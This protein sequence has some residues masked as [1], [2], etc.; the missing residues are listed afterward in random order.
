MGSWHLPLVGGM[1]NQ[2][3]FSFGEHNCAFTV[4]QAKNLVLHYSNGCFWV[5]HFQ[6]TCSMNKKSVQSEENMEKNGKENYYYNGSE[7]WAHSLWKFIWS[8][9]RF[10]SPWFEPQ[11]SCQQCLLAVKLSL[12]PLFKAL[13]WLFIWNVY[14]AM[15]FWT[16]GFIPVTLAGFGRW[17]DP[18]LKSWHLQWKGEVFRSQNTELRRVGW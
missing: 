6:G 8:Q 5:R 1:A 11:D 2:I 3:V 14:R 15:P 12:Q 18:F 7:A 4:C 9:F 16:F 17:M 10:R 13:I